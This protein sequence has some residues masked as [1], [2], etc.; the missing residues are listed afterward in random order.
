VPHDAVTLVVAAAVLVIVALAAS[1]IPVRRAT[2]LDP[3]IALR[4]E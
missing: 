4:I 3:T 2:R 1:L